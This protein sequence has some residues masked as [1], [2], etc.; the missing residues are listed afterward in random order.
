MDFNERTNFNKC[1]DSRSN[2]YKK[3]LQEQLANL[4]YDGST[5]LEKDQH[6]LFCLEYMHDNNQSKATVRAGYSKVSCGTQ[7]Y[8]LMQRA[9][10]QK[11]IRYLKTKRQ[12][13]KNISADRI[14]EELAKIAFSDIFDFIDITKG[15]NIRF[16][17]ITE[18]RENGAAI[19][20]IS[21]STGTT[22][23]K[24]VKLHD[25]L[26]ALDML[27]SHL[28][29]YERSKLAIKQEE[30][31]LKKKRVNVFEEE[32]EDDGFVDA[33]KKVASVMKGGLTNLEKEIKLEGIED[34]E[35]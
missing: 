21:S 3:Q 17:S 23:T 11:R 10:V 30:L 9:D 25:K 8:L 4:D 7:S 26:R 6:E 34:N 5:P 29:M 2:K 15:N 18:M 31:A 12:E 14:L 1:G 24:K 32:I 13:R 27:M 33:M 20:E 19:Q 22:R 35:T 16:K 28:E